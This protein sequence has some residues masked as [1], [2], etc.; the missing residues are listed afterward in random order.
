MSSIGQTS[1]FRRY[2]TDD[3]FI[4][5]FT[6]EPEGA[7]DVLIPILH[8]NELWRSNL[9][10]I[11]REIPVNRLLIG[12]GGCIDD[13]LEVVREFPRVEIFDHSNFISLGYSIRKLIEV[14]ETEWFIYLHSDVYL[15][16]GWFDAMRK[17][18]NKYDWFECSQRATILVE[19]L[20]DITKNKRGF[21]IGGSHMGRKA[22]FKDVL[23]Q[24]DDDYLYR[25]E[26]VILFTLL[27]R[28]GFRYGRIGEVFHYHQLMYK[29]SPTS[30]KI[31]SLSVQ[32]EMSREEEIRTYMMQAK[33]FVKYLE[34]TPILVKE[35]QRCVVRL[36]GLKA[37][38]WDEFKKWVKE[39]NPVWLKHISKK[40]SWKYRVKQFALKM[41]RRGWNK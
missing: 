35:L 17:Y 16:E 32:L 37:L 20:R 22:A 9:L 8:T 2:Y 25:N 24:I 10:S 41:Y 40:G 30:R 12:D 6:T 18:Q 29:E 13:S 4:D 23:H 39:T 26:D 33:G 1:I 28:A 19:Y 7:V 11:Y 34:P 21:G 27:E 14:V 38:D 36:L 31:K 5:R 15:P 3:P